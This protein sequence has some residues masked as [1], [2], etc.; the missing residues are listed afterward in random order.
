M[1]NMFLYWE[2]G[3]GMRIVLD[4]SHKFASDFESFKEQNSWHCDACCFP[5]LESSCFALHA[6]LHKE[7]QHV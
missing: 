7:D 4:I 6:C 3:N 5:F 2:P 1:Y